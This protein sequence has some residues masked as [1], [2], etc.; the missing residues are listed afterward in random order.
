MTHYWQPRTLTS[1][2]KHTHHPGAMLHRWASIKCERDK[3]PAVSSLANEA[4]NVTLTTGKEWREKSCDAAGEG[5]R[6]LKGRLL[7]LPKKAAE[8]CFSGY[9]LWC[10]SQFQLTTSWLC[11]LGE[12][13][14]PLWASASF[15]VGW[16]WYSISLWGC[17][18]SS[19][20]TE[21]LLA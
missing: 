19:I 9:Q 18:W 13:T 1:S 10:E 14:S 3:P 8:C 6:V 5:P 4:K 7:H 17:Y 21:C 11:I 12:V 20:W 16:R 15:P 2:T